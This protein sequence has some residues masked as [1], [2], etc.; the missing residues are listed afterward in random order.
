MSIQKTCKNYL[1]LPFQEGTSFKD[2]LKHASKRDFI[3]FFSYFTVIL[4]L[5]AGSVLLGCK[6]WK[7]ICKKEGTVKKAD[8]QRAEHLGSG[9][10][11]SSEAEKQEALRVAEEE[12]AT[13]LQE[14]RIRN[15]DKKREQVEKDKL[16]YS[17]D[18]S[19]W[20][21]K[22][23]K[24]NPLI[25]EME[26]YISGPFTTEIDIWADA[27]IY[28]TTPLQSGK[29]PLQVAV[30]KRLFG[31]AEKI[32][33]HGADLNVVSGPMQNS[34]LHEA[35]INDDVELIRGL[36]E[37]G[38]DTTLKN[39]EGKTAHDIALEHGHRFILILFPS[40]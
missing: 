38:I 27:K 23:K 37:L 40:E 26:N 17:R 2:K 34:L 7:V 1:T 4:P 31:I 12:K 11:E 14:A 29:T 3:K 22:L 25:V 24:S 16:E 32:I 39:A 20:E 6:C 18:P 9:H 5:I 8:D 21:K 28:S 35:S 15:L 36:I 19:Q 10:V 30:N 13:K 33:A